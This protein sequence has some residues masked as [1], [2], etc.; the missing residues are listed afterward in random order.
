MIKTGKPHI[1]KVVERQ[2]SN[3]EC[4]VCDG[5]KKEILPT[6]YRERASTYIKIHTW[7]NDWGSESVE[8][9]EYQEMCIPCA[10]KYAAQYIEKASGTKQIECE[11]TWLYDGMKL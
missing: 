3:V 5:C 8:S 1:E 4:I 7:H 6:K 9:H 10:A 2:Y 11:T